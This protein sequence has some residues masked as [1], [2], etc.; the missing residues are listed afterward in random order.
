MDPCRRILEGFANPQTS[1]SS[2][3]AGGDCGGTA[4]RGGA[5]TGT[6]LKGREELLDAL[7]I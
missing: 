1:A 2:R 4:D 6:H 7:F 3:T 5:K